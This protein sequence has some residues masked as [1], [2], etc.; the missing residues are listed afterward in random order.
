VV[1]QTETTKE[2]AQVVAM[3]SLWALRSNITT[4]ETQL[5]VAGIRLILKSSQSLRRKL[6]STK[7]N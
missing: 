7:I 5:L 2:E 3:I 6:K 4:G 1:S